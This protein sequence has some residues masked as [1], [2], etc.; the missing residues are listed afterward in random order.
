MSQS[1]NSELYYKGFLCRL[2]HDKYGYRASAI[3]I[4]DSK[5]LKEI[6]VKKD[7]IK[8][9]G[10]PIV[11]GSENKKKPKQGNKALYIQKY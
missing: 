11:L 3:L 2:K 1:Q 8:T 6:K 5:A 10:P 7:A 9:D 4:K